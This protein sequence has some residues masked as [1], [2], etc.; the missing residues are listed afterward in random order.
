ML[1]CRK[2]GDAGCPYI[3]WRELDRSITVGRVVA[4]LTDG[5]LRKHGLEVTREEE[6]W[7]TYLRNFAKGPF[8][9]RL[10]IT[11]QSLSLCP[12]AEGGVY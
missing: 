6:Y 10:R 11:C 1:F 4:F 7:L 5:C 8:E 9:R 3:E 12:Y 2:A